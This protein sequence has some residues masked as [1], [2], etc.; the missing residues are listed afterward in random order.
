MWPAKVVLFETLTNPTLKVVDPRVVVEAA[1]KVGAISV[2]DN[3]NLRIGSHIQVIAN[4]AQTLQRLLRSI[5]VIHHFRGDVLGVHSGCRGG[6]LRQC[7]RAGQAQKQGQGQCWPSVVVWNRK[8]HGEN[9]HKNVC[10]L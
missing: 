8:L 6:I 5:D 4:I 7:G 9:G 3:N 2:C 10:R 1:R